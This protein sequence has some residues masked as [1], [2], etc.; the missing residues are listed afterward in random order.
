[1]SLKVL[2]TSDWHLGKKLFKK[3]RIYEQE[4]FLNWLKDTIASEKIDILL[5]CGDIFDTPTPPND[6]ITL[7]FDFLNSVSENTQCKI[8]IIPGNHDSSSFISAPLKLL[9]KHNI[10]IISGID[11]Y[12]ENNHLVFNFNGQKIIIKALP[13]FRTYELYNAINKTTHENI[14]KNDIQYFIEDFF[15]YWPDNNDNDFKLVMAHHA[16]GNFIA[17]ESEQA[18]MLSGLESIPESWLGDDF[19]YMALG[20]IHKPQAVKKEKNIYYSGSPIPLRFSEI[21]NKKVNILNISGNNFELQQKEIPVFRSILQIKGN[22]DEIEDLIKTKLS[23]N[24]SIAKPF[25][26]IIVTMQAPD[27]SFNDK[28]FNLTKDLGAEL[29]SF[30]PY[31]SQQDQEEDTDEIKIHDLN[32]NELFKLYYLQKFPDAKTVPVSIMNNFIDN[33]RETIDENH[34]STS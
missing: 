15:K 17:S 34:L 22:K 5:I 14:D 18:L 27:N 30:I 28:I 10:Y 3:S 1:M 13:Y 19:N 33:L 26:E 8:I 29:L 21:H 4:S 24:S 11:N 20:H 12:Q 23:T 6:A 16:F 32:I 7:Y 31:Y 2:H 9:A 25:I